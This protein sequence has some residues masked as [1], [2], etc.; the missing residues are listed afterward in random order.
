[1]LNFKR[2]RAIW[3]S[4]GL[5]ILCRGP[6]NY[7]QS[8]RDYNIWRYYLVLGPFWKGPK[9]KGDVQNRLTQH[10]ST[11]TT[12]PHALYF[13]MHPWLHHELNNMWKGRF[14]ITR[15][16]G[17]LFDCIPLWMHSHLFG[18]CLDPMFTPPWGSATSKFTPDW[19]YY[20]RD[21]S[22]ILCALHCNITKWHVIVIVKNVSQFSTNSTMYNQAIKQH[23]AYMF[24]VLLQAISWIIMAM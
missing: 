17:R 23:A 5:C 13:E 16:A 2:Q 6:I 14:T 24:H 19:G 18:V 21:C 15:A 11:P 7:N 12:T 3:E 22:Y 8:L 10:H 9:I 20:I 1:M 4:G